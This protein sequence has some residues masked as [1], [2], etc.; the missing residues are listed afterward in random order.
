M[1]L[2]VVG[3]FAFTIQGL[4]GATLQ[5]LNHGLSTGALF[6]LVGMIYDRRHTRMI[7]D[8]GGIAHKSPVLASFFLV[9]TLSSIG[10]PGLNG[11]VGE[12]LALVGIFLANRTYA[13]VAASG[14]ILGAVYMLWMYQR[15]FLGPVS[16]QANAEMGDI[17]SR[18]RLILIPIVVMMLWMGVYSAP[19]LRRMDASLAAVQKRVHDAAPAGGY[20]VG[21]QVGPWRPGGTGR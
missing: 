7:G 10:L 11:F 14:M 3:I 1:G 4:E 17:D 5:M 2:I 8:F 6:L 18:E 19:F 20:Y 12:V 13:V 16:D 15:V 21:L 9:V